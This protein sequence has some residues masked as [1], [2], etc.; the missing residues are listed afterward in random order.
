MSRLLSPFFYCLILMSISGV[1]LF[2]S[3][4]GPEGNAADGKRWYRMHNCYA[5]HG[6]NGYDGRGP[7]IANPSMSY[8][9]FVSRL[10]N[11][12]TQVMPAYSKERINDQDAAD[13][14]A[15]LKSVDEK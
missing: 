4:S 12:K 2:S 9:S 11:A 3:C 8:R 6:E 5:C 7:N 1:L 14:L 10:R 13:I 15:Y